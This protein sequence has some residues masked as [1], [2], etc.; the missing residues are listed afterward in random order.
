MKIVC[1]V[2]HDLDETVRRIVEVHR[3]SNDVAVIDLRQDRDYGKIVD[4]IA[5][6]DKTISW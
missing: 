5:G 6:S 4:L 2:K 1:L 3:K